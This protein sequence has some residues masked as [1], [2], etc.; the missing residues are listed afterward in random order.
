MLGHVSRDCVS[1]MSHEQYSVFIYLLLRICDA[2]CLAL[3]MVV[4]LHSKF[5][6]N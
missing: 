5:K 1:V 4:E 2:M 3:V 6:A